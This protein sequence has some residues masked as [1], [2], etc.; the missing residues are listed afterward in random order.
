LH[1]DRR[2]RKQKTQSY[3]AQSLY[4]TLISFF[5]SAQAWD[6]KDTTTERHLEPLDP[7]ER[8]AENAYTKLVVRGLCDGTT[9]PLSFCTNTMQRL[10]RHAMRSCFCCLL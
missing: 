10:L 8:R 2:E 5:D 7:E 9:F 1:F 4:L 3:L 6:E